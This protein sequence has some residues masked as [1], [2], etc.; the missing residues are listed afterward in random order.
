MYLKINK[1][2]RR[3]DAPRGV[4]YLLHFD[5]P[6]RAQ[7]GKGVQVA[8]HYIGWCLS[9]EERMKEHRMGRGSVLVAV[10]RAR[11]IGF[12]IAKT[13]ENVTRWTERRLKNRGGASRIC[14]ICLGAK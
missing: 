6:V 13:W 14:P 2:D 1:R 11:G 9:L 3:P 7:S 4:V 10:A 12:T 5:E 8:K